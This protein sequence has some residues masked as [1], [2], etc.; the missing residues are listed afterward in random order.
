M[1]RARAASAGA[2]L[3]PLS[4]AGLGGLLLWLLFGD[5]G[6]SMRERAALPSALELMRRHA[7]SD[8]TTSLLLSTVPAALSML[9]VPLAGYHSDRCRSHLG[10]RKPFLLVAAPMGCLAMLGLAAAPALA[11]ALDA[12]L[13]SWSP[14]LHN[15]RLMLF[16]LFWAAFDC[17]AISAFSLF[18][19][20]VNDLVPAGLLGRFFAV[21]RIVGLSVGIAYQNWIFALTDHYLAEILVGVGLFFCVPILAMALMV[22]ETPLPPS[23]VPTEKPTRLPLLFPFK[24]V[25]E[26]FNHRAYGWAVA[27]FML[28]GVTFSPFNTFYLHYAHAAGIAKAT[29]GAL[30]AAGYATSIVSAF[31]IGWLADRFGAVRVSTVIMTVYCATSAAGFAGV[32]DAESFRVF[33]FAHVVIS[34]AWFTAAASMPMALFPRARFVQFNSTKDLMVIFGTILVSSIQGPMLDLSGHAYSF[35]LLAGTVFSLL[36]LVCLTRLRA[37]AKAVGADAGLSQLRP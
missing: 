28:A 6:V 36:S 14:G 1:N 16:C 9:L 24:H 22:K 23:T 12:A 2:A 27:A 10:R 18:N 32:S 8:T 15:C 26:C 30:T 37:S 4:L 17:A 33:Y 35:T 19:G 34:G 29:L 5:L 11:V 20:L 3:L 7:A 21:F 25:L 13:G 31:A